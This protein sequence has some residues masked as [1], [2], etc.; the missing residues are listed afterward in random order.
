[1]LN[2]VIRAKDAA[3]DTLLHPSRPTLPKSLPPDDDKAV[4]EALSK[5][6]FVSKVAREQVGDADIRRLRPGQW[7]ND[8]II[9]FYG[10]LINARADAQKG[11]VARG[12]ILKAFYLSTFFW[13][14]L[15]NDGYEKGKLDR[16]T[17]K[18]SALRFL[19][20]GNA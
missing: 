19:V 16:W 10:A 14:K 6:G 5:S 7:L 1:M 12:K 17:K 4:D 13:T 9:N 11:D 20:L 3:I 18:V 15:T 2:K 8:E